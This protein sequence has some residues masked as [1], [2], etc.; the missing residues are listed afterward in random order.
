MDDGTG[1][2]ANQISAR[3]LSEPARV[4]LMFAAMY[5]ITGISTPYLPVWLDSRGIGIGEIGV[6]TIVPQLVRLVGSPLIGFE[7]DRRGAHRELVI[8]SCVL[9]LAAW[10]WLART[11]GIAAAMVG[12]MLVAAANTSW[13]LVE[14]IAMAGVRAGGHDYGRMRLWGSVSFVVANLVGGWVVGWY[15]NGAVIWLLTVGAAACVVIARLLPI[16]SPTDLAS[17]AR[18]PLSWAD[19]RDLLRVR[20]LPLLLL[21]AGTVQGAHGMFY[22]YG[23][24]HWQAQGIDARWLGL[25]WALGL[26]T[27]IALFWW[28][29][30]IIRNLGAIGLLLVGAS[31]SVFR[32]IVMGFDP[33]L[34]VLLPLQI[35]HGITFGASHLGVM[36]ALA[37]ITPPDRTATA[38]ALYS[39]AAVLGIIL[40]TAL[41]SRAYP[42]I[43]GRMYLVMAAM[44]A[45]SVLATETIR[46]QRA[47]AD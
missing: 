16:A 42:L 45:V 17:L 28:S 18:R 44:A 37:D 6:L 22:T 21:A 33:P 27:E 32:W 29:A 15:G 31:V 7:A 26:M 4:A 25:L 3:A 47:R 5:W 35:L 14:S 2:N 24:L 40:A 19:A 9:G 38:Q 11:T 36:H 13:P 1:R 30:R 39:V 43:G 23:T 20:Q 46:Q 12:L 10:L 8:A 34:A 41:A